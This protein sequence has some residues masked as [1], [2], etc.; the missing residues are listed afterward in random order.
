MSRLC[1]KIFL[2]VML[3]ITALST[4]SCYRMPGNHDYSV[5]PTTNNPAVTHERRDNF[6]PSVSY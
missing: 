2:T 4:T 6:L 3:L 5:V 1:S